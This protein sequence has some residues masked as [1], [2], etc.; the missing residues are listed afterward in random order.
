MRPWAK[1]WTNTSERTLL[2]ARHQIGLE[3]RRSEPDELDVRIEPNVQ[4]RP[5]APFRPQTLL[6]GS[7]EARSGETAIRPASDDR[8]VAA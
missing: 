3:S 2:K 8:S 4:G 7:P 1:S 6:K 5:I